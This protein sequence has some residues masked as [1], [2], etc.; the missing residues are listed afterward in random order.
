[1]TLL[2]W[3]SKN[4]AGTACNNNINDI[5]NVTRGDNGTDLNLHS[6]QCNVIAR[7]GQTL[8]Y[9]TP[10]L[11]EIFKLNNDRPENIRL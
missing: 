5:N 6:V 7:H 3:K 11:F 9:D 2:N 10:R 8:R 4:H 1:M